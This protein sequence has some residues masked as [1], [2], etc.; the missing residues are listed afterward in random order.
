[1][2]SD[3]RR[4]P[5]RLSTH[6]EPP[7]AIAEP[8]TTIQIRVER[9][10]QL[11]DVL[12][13]LPIVER[14]LSRSTEEFIVGW[15]RELPWRQPLRIVIHVLFLGRT[16]P[17]EVAK[18]IRHHFQYR[19]DRVRRDLKELFRVG[20]I[21]LAIGLTVLAVCIVTAQW[22]VAGANDSYLARF[23][24]EGLI[25]VGW[26]ANWRPIEIFL[27]DW[28]QLWR[29]RTLYT[30]IAEA[31]ITLRD[32]SRE[33]STETDSYREAFTAAGSHRQAQTTT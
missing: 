2:Y 30:R 7:A 28:W 21:S 27:Y 11:F 6:V 29:Q 24:Y 22:L 4:G 19:S 17:Q 8:P 25:I 1:M 10:G 9:V 15:A 26:V 12:D 5:G 23:F 3:P 31:D 33:A 14:D 16:S 13:P 20:G 18:A 32:E